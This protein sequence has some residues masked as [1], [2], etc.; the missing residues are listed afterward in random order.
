MVAERNDQ[1]II[2]ERASALIVLA[3]ARVWESEGWQVKI[4]DADG[5][6]FDPA[7]LE[8]VLGPGYNWSPQEPLSLSP[9]YQAMELTPANLMPQNLTPHDLASQYEAS[10]EQAVQASDPA[11]Q[12]ETREAAG[13]EDESLD[14][15]ESAEETGDYQAFETLEETDEYGDFE[16]YD[17]AEELAEELQPHH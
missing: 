4:T 15:L 8:K 12:A 17:E 11:S 2:K 6:E 1:K 7:G 5:A 3:N 13:L 10:P 9:Q 14:E 16:P